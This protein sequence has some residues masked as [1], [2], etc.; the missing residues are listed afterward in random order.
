MHLILFYGV[1]FLELFVLV[2]LTVPEKYLESHLNTQQIFGIN[3][4]S[5]SEV[6]GKLEDIENHSY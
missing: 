5:P 1:L 6:L 4:L 3:V 2:K